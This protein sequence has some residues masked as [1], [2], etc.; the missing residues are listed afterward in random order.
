MNHIIQTI[1]SKLE[2]I[3]KLAALSDWI[4]NEELKL[5]ASSNSVDKSVHREL[6][7][8]I[9][10]LR[11]LIVKTHGEEIYEK[12]TEGFEKNYRI[13]Q[14]L[15]LLAETYPALLPSK[16]QVAEDSKVK[17]SMKKG[18]ELSYGTVLSEFLNIPVIAYHI[19]ESMQL[20]MEESISYQNQ[21]LTE[22]KIEFQTVTLER[23]NNIGFLTL[24]NIDC[25][26]AEDFTLMHEM[27]LAADLILLDPKIDVGVIRG[28]V[29]NH[30]KYKG[31]RVFCSGVNLTKLY[32]GELPYMFYVARELGLMNKIYRGLTSLDGIKDG[33]EKPWISVVDTHAI[34]GGCQIMLICDYVIAADDAYVTIPARTEGFIPG[35]ANLRLKTY[36]GHVLARK[37]INMNHKVQANTTD[38]ML[39]VDEV[40][41]TKDID[42]A[43]Y[44][45]V[46]EISQTGIQGMI[47]NR[48]AFR[49]GAEPLETFRNYMV[50]FSKQQAQCMFDNEIIE[51]LEKFWGEKLKRK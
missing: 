39:L 41:P 29:M 46:N 2:L 50:M 5:D 18:H 40:Q 8:K 25:L 44:K 45:V 48:K 34:G 21:F 7:S 42:T 31:K 38:G 26:N 9:S 19:M 16:E 36:T 6:Q 32:N 23:V 37:M 1:K 11:G 4:E 22:G 28:D 12:A 43:V 30:K 24:T 27:E 35:L 49:I 33:I 10:Y 15:E 47:S 20:P 14:L 3:K 13:E 51:N 17:L